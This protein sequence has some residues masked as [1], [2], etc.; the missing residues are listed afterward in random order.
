MSN[1]A[2]TRRAQALADAVK[3]LAGPRKIVLQKRLGQTAV[4][5]AQLGV[6]QGRDPYGAPWKPLTSRTGRPLRRTG[7]NIQR[8]WTAGSEGPDSFVFGSRFKYLAT[9]QYGAVI[10]PK[11]GK[12]LRIPVGQGAAIYAVVTRRK[13]VG[14]SAGTH[15]KGGRYE[16]HTGVEVVGHETRFVYLRQ[17]TIP[18]RQLVPEQK[19]GGLG[20]KW[21]GA[22]SRT[23]RR[24][25][26]ET[27]AKAGAGA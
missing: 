5:Q 7:N 12:F 24:Y 21:L 13:R 17:V 25:I 22:F 15:H 4:A 6:R 20:D 1:E 8:S 3:S 18:R 9:H 10:K 11:N 23:V 14:T 16:T 27:L 19:T 26:Q 2:S